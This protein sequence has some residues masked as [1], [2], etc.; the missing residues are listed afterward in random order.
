MG[1]LASAF[2]GS[3]P[4][5]MTQGLCLRNK[6]AFFKFSDK[7]R[8]RHINV[9]CLENHDKLH[10]DKLEEKITEMGVMMQSK[11]EVFENKLGH[12]RIYLEEKNAKIAA[13]EIRLE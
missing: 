2:R 5:K 13:L 10:I 3:T 11:L 7:C 1:S 8:F 12:Q 4:S 9:K 6:F